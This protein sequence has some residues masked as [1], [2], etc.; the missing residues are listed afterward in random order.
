MKNLMK[1]AAV[2]AVI[3][4]GIV[5]YHAAPP[6]DPCPTCTNSNGSVTF[7]PMQKP[8]LCEPTA[9]HTNGDAADLMQMHQIIDL[10]YATNYP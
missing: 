5:S 1:L 9:Y 6:A 10:Y 7:P 8:M 4:L 2:L 3:A